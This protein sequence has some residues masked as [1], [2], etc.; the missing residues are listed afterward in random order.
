[1]DILNS[2]GIGGD[3]AT[4]IIS[5]VVGLVIL[6][7]GYIIARIVS[8]VVRKGLNG[9][10]LDSRLSGV[11]GNNSSFSI[12]SI[13]ATVV[14]WL[15]MLI[16]L[17]AFFTQVNLGPVSDIFN[18]L[19]GSATGFLP[20]LISAVVLG[21]I[22]YGIAYVVRML[23]N[24]AGEAAGLDARL[25]K[26]GA[27]S[28]E[29]GMSITRSLASAA[30]GLILLFFLPGIL[31]ALEMDGMLG[32]VQGLMDTMLAFI[33]NLIGAAIIF[34]IAY[35]VAKIVREI[36]TN[37]LVAVGVD[38]LG[39]KA[40]MSDLKI[41]KLGG[42]LVYVMILIPAAI[43]ALDRLG[44]AAISGPATNMLNMIMESI[45]GFIGAFA[46]L[47]ISY[48]IG[49]FITGLLTELL[50]S[51]GVDSIPAKLGINMNT[52]LS[53]I[54]N[55]LVMGF[56]MLF[57]ATEAAN[58]LGFASLNTVISQILG[59]AGQVLMGVIIIGIGLFIA[60]A[61]RDIILRTG[62]DNAAT[63]GNIARYGILALTTVMGLQQM[64]LGEGVV[65]DVF[66]ILIA[67][68]GV[69]AALAF[70]LGGR[71][72]AGREADRFVKSLRGDK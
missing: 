22:A 47:G 58:M 30:F 66:T 23:I 15:I 41:S 6:L 4:G 72:V 35:F 62:G 14:F 52:S 27:T 3:L 38:N 64:G 36:L 69:A 65:G 8:G 53:S 1:M 63:L 46:V 61:A 51:T 60:N 54:I 42:T 10:G 12:T 40:G 25:T 68:M 31:G 26:T 24:N 13:L 32:P 18:D 7:I 19:V 5:F 17:T 45:P 44:V 21:A 50:A 37:I 67:A 57:A 2:L 9:V 43:A 29:G 34:G 59:F 55:Y 28:A 71:E 16:A 39:A 11:M 33:P 70:G 48:F 20:K 49:K 56:I